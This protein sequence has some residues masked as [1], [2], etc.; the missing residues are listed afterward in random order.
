MSLAEKLAPE[1]IKKLIPYQSA[2][3]IGGTGRLWLNAN[4]LETPL[5]F[6]DNQSALHR[7]PDFLPNDIAV[8]YQ[9]YCETSQPTL[10]VRGADEAI[11]LLVR[12]FCQPGKDSITICSP[13][14]AMYQ[15]C[16]ESMAIDVID[17][18]LQAP[19]F[20][21]D[22]DAVVCAAKRSNLVFLCSPNNPTGQLLDRDSII[23]ILEQTQQHALVVVDEAYIEFELG[24]SVVELIDHYPNLVVIRTLSKAF[25]LAAVRCGF[26]IAQPSVLDFIA[27]LIPPYPMP[28]SSAEIVLNALSPNGIA[29]VR[30]HTQKLLAT[31]QAFVDQ[32]AHLD[33]IERVYPSATNFVLVRTEPGFPL[34]ELLLEQ[35]VVTRNQ[36]HEPNLADC[37]RITIGSEASMNEVGKIICNLPNRLTTSTPHNKDIDHEQ[38]A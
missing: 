1:N 36:A 16:A 10:A 3:R 13:T 11:D 26:I 29:K 5:L 33:W 24:Q 23:A 30:E 12:T 37:V 32:I 27:K 15:F 4:E 31:K 17:C 9:A 20:S 34:F 2:R 35:G 38:T 18:P 22:V 7:Y 19:D 28:D 14:Y 6:Q 8:A 25:G 21:L